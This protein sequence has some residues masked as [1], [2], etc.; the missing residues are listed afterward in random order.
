MTFVGPM[1]RL[2]AGRRQPRSPSTHPNNNAMAPHSATDRAA[3]KKND[4]SQEVQLGAID[5]LTE[6]VSEGFVE[7][8]AGADA[9]ASGL[10][11]D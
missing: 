5:R 10:G 2:A 3:A 11:S 8:G 7:G 1:M 4:A 9:V 6:S